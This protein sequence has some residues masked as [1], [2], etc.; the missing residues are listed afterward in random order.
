LT[1]ESTDSRTTLLSRFAAKSPAGD[2]SATI[3]SAVLSTP[4]GRETFANCRA[5]CATVPGR[6]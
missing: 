4:S 5:I 6:T 2:R 3:E 1:A